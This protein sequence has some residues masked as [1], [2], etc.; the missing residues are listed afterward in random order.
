MFGKASSA[1]GADE[2]AIDTRSWDTLPKKAY[3][4]M[5]DN[6]GLVELKDANGKIIAKEEVDSGKKYLSNCSIT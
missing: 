1:L 6:N 5:M 2:A 4:V 3:A